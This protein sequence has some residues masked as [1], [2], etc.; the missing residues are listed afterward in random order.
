MAN[1]KEYTQYFYCPD[2]NKYVKCEG[3]IFY[4]IKN[5]VEIQ[6][7]FYD[8]ILLGSIYTE[9]ISEEEYYAHVDKSV[10]NYA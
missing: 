1:F 2:Y 7:D 5:G 9:D 3:G 4:S 6:N 8:K 10:Y